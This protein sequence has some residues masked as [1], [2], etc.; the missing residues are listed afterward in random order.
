MWTALKECRRRRADARRENRYRTLAFEA[1]ETRVGRRGPGVGVGAS[2]SGFEIQLYVILIYANTSYDVSRM[3]QCLPKIA[4]VSPHCP[5]D[6]TIGAAAAT[7]DGL[8]LLAA[9]DSW[10]S[11]ARG[12]IK[13]AKG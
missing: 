1:L 4:L 10:R 2:G 11:A 8:K 13:P 3:R 5:V 9:K 6:F 7:R 12:S